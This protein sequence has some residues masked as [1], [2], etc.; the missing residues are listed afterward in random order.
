LELKTGVYFNLFLF[1]WKG[2]TLG[3]FEMNYLYSIEI[4][5]LEIM[6]HSLAGEEIAVFYNQCKLAKDGT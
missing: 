1:A 3:E 6:D 4:G 5:P 2:A